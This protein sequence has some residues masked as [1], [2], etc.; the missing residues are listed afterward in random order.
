[1]RECSDVLA[2]ATGRTGVSAACH[3]NS[4]KDTHS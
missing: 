4:V 2:Q 1:M 3:N